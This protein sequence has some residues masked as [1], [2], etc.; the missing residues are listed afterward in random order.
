MLIETLREHFR[1]YL[2]NEKQFIS[3]ESYVY[4]SRKCKKT[5]SFVYANLL[6]NICSDFESLIRAY[7]NMENN[8]E[9][10]IDEIITLINS[11]TSLTAILSETCQF[12]NTDY[13]VFQPLK[14]CTNHKDNINYFKWWDANNKIKHNKIAKIFHANQE[15]VLHALGALYILNRYILSI[16]A[17]K[18]F[19]EDIFLNDEQLFE[20]SNLKSKY[21]SMNSLIVSMI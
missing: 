12:R 21:I 19:G 15:N 3:T 9:L 4:V 1:Y 13:A 10:K 8:E 16:L 2:A 17:I 7:F 6:M 20:L 11:D 5:Y 14:V 18:G